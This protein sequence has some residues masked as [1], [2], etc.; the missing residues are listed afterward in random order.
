MQQPTRD[1]IEK[2]I[3]EIRNRVQKNGHENEIVSIKLDIMLKGQKAVNYKVMKLFAPELTDTEFINLI[4]LLGLE[5]GKEL[6]KDLAG[7]N[8]IQI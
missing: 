2:R 8:K 5:E 1:D 6:L 7:L 3:Q 4:F